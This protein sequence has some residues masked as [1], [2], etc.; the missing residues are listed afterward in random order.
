MRRSS[1]GKEG[2]IEKGPAEG[3]E[4]PLCTKGKKSGEGLR[5]HGKIEWGKEGTMDRDQTDQC[6]PF[7]Q[8]GGVQ[9][10]YTIN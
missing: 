5:R 7:G 6:E 2:C 1:Q 9:S 8:E 10:L 3:E 4:E